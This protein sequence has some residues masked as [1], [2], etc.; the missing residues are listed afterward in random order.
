MM[1]IEEIRFRKAELRMTN[2]MLSERSGVPLGTVQKVLG[3]GTASPRLATLLALERALRE[4]S[5]AASA[6]ASASGSAA[7]S[8]R[9]HFPTEGYREPDRTVSY[10]VSS[11]VPETMVREKPEYQYGTSPDKIYTVADYYALPDE[12][13]VELIDGRFYDMAAPS[14]T[15]QLI[16][17]RLFT[18][19][20]LQCDAHGSD[21]LVFQAPAD[22]QLDCD[23]YTMVQPDIFALCDRSRLNNRVYFGAPDLVIEV[24]SRS[25]KTKD[26]VLKRFK[27]KAAGVKE[28]WMI[29]PETRQILVCIFSPDAEDEL[30]LYGFR[31]KIPVGI[32]GGECMVDFAPIDDIIKTVFPEG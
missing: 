1:T 13:R 2:Q 23:D 14:Y 19:L 17:G 29:D 15:H 18:Q 22:V 5:G 9:P 11:S 16:V 4:D 31:D 21:C 7:A 3:G 28:Y 6:S 8:G 24:L 30:H 20:L 27:Y 32:S 12:R 25:T 10:D 26:R